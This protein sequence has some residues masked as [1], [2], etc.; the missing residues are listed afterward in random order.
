MR[1]RLCAVLVVLGAVGAAVATTAPA[2]AQTPPPM[3][4]FWT[5]NRSV[6]F[7]SS[8]R[9]C[10]DIRYN[11]PS[12][13]QVPRGETRVHHQAW[14]N[15]WQGSQE[16]V[17]DLYTHAMYRSDGRVEAQYELRVRVNWGGGTVWCGSIWAS[18]EGMWVNDHFT[19]FW[20]TPLASASRGQ[21]INLDCQHQGTVGAYFRLDEGRGTF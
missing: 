12:S 17:G 16:I 10:P 15:C 18:R 5:R 6:S 21:M 9:N 8:F 4:A 11:T 3:V 2:E 20:Y 1:K 14:F 13:V 19:M 7:T